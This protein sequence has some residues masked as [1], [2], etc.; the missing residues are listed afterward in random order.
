MPLAILLLYENIKTYRNMATSFYHQILTLAASAI[1]FPTAAAAQVAPDT[2]PSTT[3]D[4]IVVEAPE[5]IRKADMDVYYPPQSAV[6]NSSNGMQLLSNL[7][8]PS[9]TVTEALGTVKAGGQ[10]V[11]LRI[12][13]RE[14]S[15]RAGQSSS[16]V[17]YK[18]CGMD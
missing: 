17:N 16:S 1:L 6:T 4:E 3:L 11:Q 18:T 15:A 8:I 13:G 2:I 14:A 7:M 10:D 9:L 5:V 12:N